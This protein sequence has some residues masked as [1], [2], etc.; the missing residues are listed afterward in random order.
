M[1]RVFADN[2]DFAF[3][4]DDL[5]LF[6]DLLNGWFNLHFIIPTLSFLLCTPSDASLVKIVHRYFY[7]HAVTGQYSNIIHSELSGYMSRNYMSIGKLYFEGR[8]GKCFH[9]HAFKFYNIILRQNNPSSAIFCDFST[10]HSLSMRV[11]I[12]TPSEVSAIV[13]S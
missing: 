4:L 2:H 9:Y 5:A 11:V 7:G 3:S 6:A 13:F 8:V 12:I 1:L 10:Y